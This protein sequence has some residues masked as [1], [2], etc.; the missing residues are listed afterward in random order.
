MDPFKIGGAIGLR[1]ANEP[2]HVGWG[3]QESHP[4]GRLTLPL[5][6][7]QQVGAALWAAG[8]GARRCK[9]MGPGI[10]E[11]HEFVALYI[12]GHFKHPGPLFHTDKGCGVQGVDVGSDHIFESGIWK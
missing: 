11:G 7:D 1:A 3:S 8:S 2:D 4:C 10:H 12:S 9:N 5:R 6:T